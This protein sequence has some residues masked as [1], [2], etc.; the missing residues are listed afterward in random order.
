MKSIKMANGV[1]TNLCR[2]L[3][4]KLFPYLDEAE[5]IGSKRHCE[6]CGA[7]CPTVGTIFA[8]SKVMK[9]TLADMEVRG[10]VWVWGLRYTFCP[11]CHYI[12][13]AHSESRHWNWRGAK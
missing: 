13:N 5:F 12:F 4:D 2:F 7:F 8:D 10:E 11:N 9:E 3:P 6:C 1:V